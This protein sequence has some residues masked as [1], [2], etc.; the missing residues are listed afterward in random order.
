MLFT[1]WKM[2]HKKA[3]EL[4]SYP[5]VWLFKVI[6]ADADLV[7]AAV[8]MVVGSVYENLVPSATSSSGRYISYN[9]EVEVGSQEHR[10]RLYTDLKAHPDIIFVL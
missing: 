7:P 9:L 2:T 1:R 10:D 3:D 4:V 8:D 6:G 5:C